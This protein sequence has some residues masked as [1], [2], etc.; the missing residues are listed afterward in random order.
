MTTLCCNASVI[1]N[2]EN[3]LYGFTY[4]N[5][6]ETTRL[7]RIEESVYGR[8]SNM[9][10]TQKLAKLRKDLSAD[11]IGQEIKPKEDTFMEDE[12]YQKD[13]VDTKIPQGSNIDYPIINEMEKKVFKQEFKTNDVNGR[14]AKLEQKE[15]GKTFN[16]DLNSRV[17]RLSQKLNPK[18]SV[19]NQNSEYNDDFYSND[20]DYL[21]DK[22]SSQH[23]PQYGTPDIDYNAYN[24]RHYRSPSQYRDNSTGDFK[25]SAIEKTMFKQTYENDN[26]ENRLSRIESGLFGTIFDSDTTPERINR[27]SSALT[28]Q[29]SA[30]RYDSNKFGQN[31]STAI[32]IGAIIL[33]VLSCIL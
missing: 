24:S 2:L 33:M 5:Q 13:I 10:D 14:L 3:Y 32:Q 31:M 12:D 18:S 4:N 9:T 6:T 16:D 11:L 29:K 1:D 17:E 28:A 30:K 20:E 23:I 19:T 25:L 8:K 26:I 27:I 7:N 15:F 21:S 22:Y